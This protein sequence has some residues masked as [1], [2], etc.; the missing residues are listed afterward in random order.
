MACGIGA[1]GA[2]RLEGGFLQPEVFESAVASAARGAERAEYLRI[3][4][5]S[6]SP[7]VRLRLETAEA[8]VDAGRRLGLLADAAVLPRLKACLIATKRMLSTEGAARV[9]ALLAELDRM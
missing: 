9:A 7:V 8:F 6:L 4:D 2:A 3:L 5:L 1:G